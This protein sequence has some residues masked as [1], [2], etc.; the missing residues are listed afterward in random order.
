MSICV[1]L[2]LY[3][4]DNNCGTALNKQATLLVGLCHCVQEQSE[5]VKVTVT[6]SP[7]VHNSAASQ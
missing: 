6:T 3:L 1:L 7:E 5:C 4:C 2:I